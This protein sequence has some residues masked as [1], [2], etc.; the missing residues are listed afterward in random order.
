MQISGVFLPKDT[1]AYVFSFLKLNDILNKGRV[2]KLW[3]EISDICFGMIKQIDYVPTQLPRKQLYKNLKEWPVE[4]CQVFD[5][6]IKGLNG[7]NFEF[8]P[9]SKSYSLQKIILSKLEG[10]KQTIWAYDYISKQLKEIFFPLNAIEV[11]QVL[12]TNKKAIFV[13]KMEEDKTETFDYFVFD[14]NTLKSESFKGSS[15]EPTLHVF[16]ERY[17]ASSNKINNNI[18]IQDVQEKKQYIIPI[19]EY[20]DLNVEDDFLIYLN[21]DQITAVGL[22]NNESTEFL[23][24]YHDGERIGGLKNISVKDLN[25]KKPVICNSKRHNNLELNNGYFSYPFSNSISINY[26]YRDVGLV[27]STEKIFKKTML[28]GELH[29]YDSYV[30]QGV[31]NTENDYQIIIWDIS[32]EGNAFLLSA[33]PFTDLIIRMGTIW[34]INEHAIQIF[35]FKSSSLEA[36]HALFIKHESDVVVKNENE[37]PTHTQLPK[38][39][40][41]INAKELKDYLMF[42]A[43]F[44]TN[45]LTR[46][47]SHNS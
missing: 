23:L 38:E 4:V 28:I 36:P 39:N 33:K 34:A 20:E 12:C 10:S 29:K 37:K 30:F 17:F 27:F 35:D 31:R 45:T 13:A 43:H 46:S 6:S 18:Y 32:K 1:L 44:F 14:L 2:C 15:H 47:Y 41:F 42:F 3:N 8:L 26:W 25:N 9:K 21:C 5:I 11:K 40:L 24:N 19:K 16:N 22:K 7:M